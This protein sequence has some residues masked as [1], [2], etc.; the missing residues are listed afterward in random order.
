MGLAYRASVEECSYQ[1]AAAASAGDQSV[2]MI[3]EHSRGDQQHD[4][5]WFPSAQNAHLVPICIRIRLCYL[6]QSAAQALP[7]FA[8][9]T[10]MRRRCAEWTSDVIHRA[11]AAF[12]WSLT[13]RKIIHAE[14]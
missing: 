11:Y 13:L 12:C 9:Q 10:G 6:R 7:H 2:T 5:L 4:V 3:H 14:K 1:F 8:S